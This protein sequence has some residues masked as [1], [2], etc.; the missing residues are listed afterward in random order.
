MI[1]RR[2]IEHVRT[3]NWT[4]VLLDFLIVVGGVFVG[5]QGQEW[6]ERREDAARATSLEQRLLSDF[7]SI[8]SDL[9]RGVTRTEEYMDAGEE[10]YAILKSGMPNKD[11]D[12][13]Q[14]LNLAGSSYPPAGGAPTYTEMVSTGDL[15]LLQDTKL[16]QALLAYDQQARQAEKVF[17]LL[18]PRMLT[19]IEAVD[20][21][22]ERSAAENGRGFPNV[23]SFDLE[24][25][26]NNAHRFRA[27]ARAN[28]NVFQ[29][30]SV[31]K[32]LAETVRD[33]LA[34]ASGAGATVKEAAQ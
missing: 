5:L 30:Y 3:Q 34:G 28:R 27:Q 10:V 24:S 17:D 31:Q 20:P 29:V 21:Y 16:R 1:L 11:V 9:E 15:D 26:R 32:D 22:I 7:D 14:L 2:V 6:S 4:A 13:G 25:L 8:I 18:L 23:V 33:R 19:A 12:F